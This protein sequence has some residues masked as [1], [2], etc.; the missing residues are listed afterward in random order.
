LIATGE[1]EVAVAQN[2]ADWQTLTDAV[3]DVFIELAQAII[4]DGEGASKF[5][6]VE[7][8]GGADSGECLDVA[9]T[10]AESPLVKTALFASD[11]NWGR[12]LAAVGRS[13]LTALDVNTVRIVINDVLIAEGGG[14]AANY[15]EQLGAAAMAQEEIHIAIDLGRGS[16]SETVWTTDLSHDY[17]RINAE[18]R[19]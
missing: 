18:Y 1:S 12:I 8:S 15:T 2:S 6:T 10:V 19:T 3:C 7:V 11:A 13:G 16:H 17:I 9:Y 14:R 4:K 5:V